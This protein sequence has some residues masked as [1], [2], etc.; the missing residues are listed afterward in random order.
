M[1]NQ[2]IHPEDCNYIFAKTLDSSQHLMLLIPK[3]QF[4]IYIDGIVNLI[5]L[6]QLNLETFS[7]DLLSV[8]IL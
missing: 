5:F 6:M 7:S 3:S 4:Y 1:P 2:H 8:V